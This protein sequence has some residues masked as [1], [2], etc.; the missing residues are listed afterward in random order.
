M[1]ET[2]YGRD[3]VVVVDLDAIAHNVR[4]F[5]RHLAPDVKIMAVVKANAYGHG[6]VQIAKTALQAGAE[7][8]AVAFEDEGIELRQAGIDAPILVLGYT[9]DHAVAEALK[10]GLTLT[11]YQHGSLRTI[12]REAANLGIKARVHVKVDTG[13]GRLGL[14]P[15]EAVDF[16]KK[17]W[18]LKHVAVEGIF[19]HYATADQAEKDYALY[20]ESQFAS[21]L[22]R[23]KQEG[24]SIQLPHIA[25]SGGAIDLS[26]RAYRMVRTGISLYGFYP[27]EQVN[28]GVVDL[29]PALT[30]KTK[31][32]DLKQPPAGMGVSYGKTYIA[33][34]NEWIA[35]VPIGYADGVN[36]HLS[37]RGFAL[38]RGQKVPIV[39]RVCMDQ[40]MLNVTDAMPVKIGDEVVLYGEQQGKCI[41]VD[42]VAKL[43]GTI[44]YEVVSTISHRI[45]RVYQKGGKIVEIVNRLRV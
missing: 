15:D 29:R 11:V 43:L 14:F 35:A 20:Q 33:D 25:N 19:T 27:S 2:N 42:E 21:V 37:N 24:I 40:L 28:R 4:Q 6:A 44:N 3:T 22:N 5:R 39:G 13:M 10:A 16:V 8:L 38:V 31:I 32:T 9:P 23:L 1:K 17:A 36:R 12:E 30:L 26:D 7:Y 45:P 18:E 41:T 34:G